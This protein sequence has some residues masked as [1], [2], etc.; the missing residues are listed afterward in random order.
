MNP[1]LRYL[2][3]GF[4]LSHIPITLTVDLQGLLGPYFPVVLQDMLR[5]YVATFNDT[6][7][8]APP[9]WFKSVILCELVFQVP[10]FF[11]LAY[12]MITKRNWLR[13][14]AIVYG[15][16]VCT[17]LVPILGTFLADDRISS[18]QRLV[19]F[20]FYLPYLL[21]PLLLTC[22]MVATPAP[23]GPRKCD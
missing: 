18:S 3:I 23:F 7:M 6:L 17:T 12:G 16:H 9:V 15:S 5:W 2:Y 21:I 8:G 20:A 14:P 10:M 22:H 19:L 13:I 4:F 11:V 1:V